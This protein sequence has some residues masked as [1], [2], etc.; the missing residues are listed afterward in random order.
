VGAQNAQNWTASIVIGIE[1]KSAQNGGS[2]RVALPEGWPRCVRSL[3]H[4]IWEFAQPAG[5]GALP[6]LP[7]MR[8]RRLGS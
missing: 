1:P 8:R 7:G 5:S 3:P 4:P 2:A 6:A